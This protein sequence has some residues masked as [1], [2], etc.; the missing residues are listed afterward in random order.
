MFMCVCMCVCVCASIHVPIHVLFLVYRIS[1]AN[2]S[3]IFQ[4]NTT[5]IHLEEMGMPMGHSFFK[6]IQ[7]VFT[8]ANGSLIGSYANGSLIF[9]MNTTCIH[10]EDN[11]KFW[12]VTGTAICTYTYHRIDLV[13]GIVHC[14][15]ACAAVCITH[16]TANL[17]TPEIH[18][19]RK[20]KVFG[21]NSNWKK[22][23]FEYF[24][25]RICKLRFF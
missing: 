18:K 4:M 19:I 14:I 21:T 25:L 2:G 6:W 8:Y 11:S 23:Q 24:K 12:I 13:D 17:N 7:L 1:Y 5:C 10:L 15:A 16:S 9:Q 20:L 3:L 22:S